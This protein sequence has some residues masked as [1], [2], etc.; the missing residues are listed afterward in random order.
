MVKMNPK[1]ALQFKRSQLTFSSANRRSSG[2]N[3]EIQC[4]VKRAEEH[5]SVPYTQVHENS[6][7]P[8]LLLQMSSFLEDTLEALTSFLRR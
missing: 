5:Q 3:E 8:Q 4:Q 2:N 6:S 7:V 1:N